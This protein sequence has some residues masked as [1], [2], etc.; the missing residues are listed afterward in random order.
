MFVP[1]GKEMALWGGVGLELQMG[2][3]TASGY[4]KH[5]FISVGKATSG[6]KLQVGIGG[7]SDLYGC[8]GSTESRIQKVNRASLKFCSFLEH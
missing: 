7:D 6:E 4:R 8:H 5:P 2:Q 1:R 3:T